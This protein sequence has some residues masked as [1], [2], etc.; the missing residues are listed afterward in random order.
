MICLVHNFEMS[1]VTDLLYVP[2]PL[3]QLGGSN[4]IIVQSDFRH[5]SLFYLCSNFLDPICYNVIISQTIFSC[6]D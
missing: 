3:N 1:F 4:P 2:L 5:T 6:V